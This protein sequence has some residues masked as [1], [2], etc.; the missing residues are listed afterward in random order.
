M[1]KHLNYVTTF[2]CVTIFLLLAFSRPVFAQTPS[3]PNI[4]VILADDL[5]YGDLGSYGHPT[6]QT[7]HLDRMALEGMRFTQFYVGA[8]VCTP[9]RAALLTGRLPVRY[10]MA[11]SDARGVFFP[12]SAH[13]LPDSEQTIASALK[14]K[15][16][17]TAVVGKWHLG[18]RT[19]FLPAN[20]GFDYYFG[21]PYSNDMIPRSGNN[22]PLLPL[23]RDTTVIEQG[24]DQS[25]LTRRYTDEVIRFIKD[26]RK[27]PF[28]IYYPN[29]FPHTP[30]YAS[31]DFSGTSRR[32]LYG[33]VVAEL[34]WSVGQILSTLKQLNLDKNTLVIFTSDNGPW[35]LRKVNGGSAGLLYEGK[36]SAYE[37]GM[38][39]PAI[40]WWPGTIKPGI[41]STALASTLDLYPT[42]LKLAGLETP[43][44]KTFDGSDITPLLTGEKDSVRSMVFYYH[45]AEL[46]AVRKGAWK[47]HF[48]TRP[49]YSQE[50]PTT[51]PIP[52]LFHIEND[53]SEKYN[54]NA[55]YPQI[56]ED[57]RKEFEEHQKSVE[58]VPSIM[59]ATAD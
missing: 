51:H 33:D 27:E 46:Y 55:E 9:S 32:G 45:R 26:H 30:L 47:A 10:G 50:A 54:L 24:V 53:P 6:I 25:T 43:R 5:G 7:P 56:V 59:E 23:Y 35:L 8:N 11:G 2:P 13:G 12:N 18:H 40:A 41:T 3:K 34:D 57:L 58:R 14:K 28:F 29:N 42:L 48:T 1:K 38:R 31:A 19:P 20:R 17:K 22:W 49:S 21:I 37:G 36:G 39:V 52:L 4:I 15:N 44:G 16:Y